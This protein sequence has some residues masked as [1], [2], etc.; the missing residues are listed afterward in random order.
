LCGAKDI[1]KKSATKKIAKH[2][3]NAALRIIEGESHGSYVVHSDKLYPLICDFLDKTV[4][5]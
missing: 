3:P 1:I 2:I 5:E 4:F